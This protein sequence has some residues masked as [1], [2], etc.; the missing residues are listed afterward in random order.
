MSPTNIELVMLGVAAVVTYA[1][2]TNHLASR[3]AHLF[4][5]DA[6]HAPASTR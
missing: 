3:I 5:R 2:L 1:T 4:R 6:D